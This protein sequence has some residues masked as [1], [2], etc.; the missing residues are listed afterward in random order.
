MVE[1]DE[2]F[3]VQLT[4]VVS[5]GG[6]AV[7]VTNDTADVDIINDDSAVLIFGPATQ[8]VAEGTAVGQGTDPNYA[9]YWITLSNP[10]DVSV[11]VEFATQDGTATVADND[12]LPLA[13]GL[14]LNSFDDTFIQSFSIEL[15]RDANIEPD[16]IFSV[17][18]FNLQAQG[19]NVVLGPSTSVTTILNDDFNLPIVEDDRLITTDSH[20]SANGTVTNFT[21]PTNAEALRI[22]F[23]GLQFDS[24]SG[25]PSDINDAFELAILRQDGTS[26][27]NDWRQ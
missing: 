6:R 18:L 4:G 7:V 5:S 26:A 25:N 17:Y 15:T 22:E 2:Y 16:E 10:V 11:F 9:G 24:I 1:L 12:Y 19:R 14:G 20:P 13:S 21:V 3:T 23:S 8:A 27:T